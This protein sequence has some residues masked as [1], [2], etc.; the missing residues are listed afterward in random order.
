MRGV[1]RPDP[2]KALMEPPMGGPKREAIGVLTSSIGRNACLRFGAGLL[3]CDVLTY[4]L[5]AASQ[6][7]HSKIL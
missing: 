3:V 6:A 4:L 2:W 7:W 1:G 5:F